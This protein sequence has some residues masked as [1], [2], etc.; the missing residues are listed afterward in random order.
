MDTDPVAPAMTDPSPVGVA[1]VDDH[2]VVIDGVR[3]WL[4]SEPRLTVLATGDDP[5]EVLRAA[6]TADVI[7]LDLRLH[8]RMMIDKLAE[9]S[10]RG[11]RVVVYSEHSDPET[12]LAVIDAGAVAFLAKHEGREHCVATVLAA[13]SDRPYVSPTLAGAL[14]G[15]PRPDRPAL[16]DKEREALLLWFQSM[17]KASV[18]R[19]MQISEHT[20][21][22]YVDR[23]RIKYTRAGRPAATKSALLARAI[24]DGLVRPEEI[25]NYR[26]YAAYD[27]PTP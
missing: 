1:I 25:G 23:A 11:R 5:D 24:E 17:S 3:A 8:G 15:D 12:M 10:V 20:V 16:S 26:S 19:R 4:A 21:K 27:R 6:P 2:P 7:L 14:V 9:L 22:Q 18:A 13:A